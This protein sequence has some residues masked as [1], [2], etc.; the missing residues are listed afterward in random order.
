VS[1]ILACPRHFQSG[2]LPIVAALN[3]ARQTTLKSLQSLFPSGERARIFKFL[4][5]ADRGQR[6]I[7]DV[8]LY[9][10]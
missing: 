1:L 6:L 8:Y 10:G 5:L 9:P 7:A 4:A 2:L 3:L